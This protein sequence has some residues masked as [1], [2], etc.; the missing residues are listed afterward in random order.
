MNL[1]HWTD[2]Q[3]IPKI[4]NLPIMEHYLKKIGNE[5]PLQNVTMLFIQHQLGNQI[6]QVDALI[7]LGLDRNKLF[8]LDIPYSANITVK[9][10]LIKNTKIP[11][12]NLINNDYNILQ[13]YTNYQRNRTQNVLIDFLN[14][15]PEKLIVLDDGAY[16]LEAMTTFKKQLPNVSIVEQTTRGIIKIKASAALSKCAKNITIINVAQSEPKT[17]LEPPFIGIA[18]CNALHKKLGTNFANKEKKC[19]VLGYGAIGKQVAASL[20]DNGFGKDQIYVYDKS[21]KRANEAQ[22]QGYQKW[23]RK[24]DVLFSLVVGC[25]GTSSFGIGDYV[26]LEDEAVLASA[27]SGSVELSREGFIE[28]A[29]SHNKDDIELD[30]SNLDESDIH[31]DIQLK[32][33]GKDVKFLNG[34]FPVNFDGRVNCV[35]TY[36]IQPTPVMMVEAAMMA[37]KSTKKDLQT[38][39]PEFGEWLKVEFCKVLGDESKMVGLDCIEK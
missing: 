23:S 30:T 27:S 1:K 4:E 5:K 34:G 11:L 24:K 13:P 19:L 25:S 36:Y 16:F 28:L 39:T 17:T 15:P 12:K 7:H 33:I 26:F 21:I 2:E 31:S 32:I 22:N 37:S 38:L 6:P 29:H 35:P 8:W 20:F 10:H 3:A 18:V 14:N 9:E